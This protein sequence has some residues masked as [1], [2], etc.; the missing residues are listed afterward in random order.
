MDGSKEA[1]QAL[2]FSRGTQKQW[3]MQRGGNENGGTV[4]T[5]TKVADGG[6]GKGE[7]VERWTRASQT[8]K[9]SNEVSFI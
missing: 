7:K 6:C 9:T 4:Q 8:A 1:E 2:K 3:S 5:P